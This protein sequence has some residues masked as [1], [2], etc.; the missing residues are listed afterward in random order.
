MATPFAVD[1]EAARGLIQERTEI[2]G[3]TQR[4][5]AKRTPI[6]SVALERHESPFLSAPPLP[7]FFA[8]SQGNVPST[9]YPKQVRQDLQTALFSL[10]LLRYP[11]RHFVFSLLFFFPS[12]VVIESQECLCAQV[13]RANASAKPRAGGLI[14]ARLFFRLSACGKRTVCCPLVKYTGLLGRSRFLLA[15]AGCVCL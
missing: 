4:R 13:S 9:S 8:K 6:C 15:A 1:P 11:R 2:A 10:Y 7:P 14:R 12:R 3:P 5:V